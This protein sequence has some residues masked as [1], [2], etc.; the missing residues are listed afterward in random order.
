MGPVGPQERGLVDPELGDLADAIGVVDKGSPVLDHGVRRGPRHPEL[1][2][3][4]G[5]RTGVGTD[6]TA[7]LGASPPGQHG[8]GADVVGVLRPRLGLAVGLGAAPP[9]LV[10]HQASGAAEAGQIPDV[11]GHP[12]L[13]LGPHATAPASHL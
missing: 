6:L 8:L 11:D 3:H 7:R 5:H 10:P 4:G 13:G 2:C 9:A 1:G 12:V